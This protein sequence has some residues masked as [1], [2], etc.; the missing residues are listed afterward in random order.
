MLRGHLAAGLI[1]RAGSLEQA[2]LI[3]SN[4]VM[5]TVMNT[6]KRVLVTGGAGFIGSHTCLEL[7]EAG[8]EVVVVDNLINSSE[9]S[10]QRVR[11]LTGCDLCFHRLDLRDADGLD[12]VF[13]ETAFDSVIHFAGLKAV[14]ESTEDPLRYYQ[15]NLT[16]TLVL[17]ETM[18]RHGVQDLVFSSSCTVYGAPECVPISEEAP[19]RPAS[20]YGRT[21]LF[22]EEILRD[23][24]TCESGWRIV[25]L[26]YF[27]PVGA[28]PSGRIGEDPRGIPDNLMPYVTQ[29]A[30]GKRDFVRV[31][32]SDYP[33]PDGTG[34]RDYIHVVDLAQGHL[35]ALA[36]M[37]NER[38]YAA[39]NLGAGRGSSVLEVIR[40]V[41]SIV[42]RDIPYELVAR[43]P[44][45]I[46][47]AWADPELA[48]RKLGWRAQRGLAE[49]C[50]DAWRWQSA[51][52][53]GYG[54]S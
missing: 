17:L 38:E 31:F 48:A 21:K 11:E 52:P 28:H 3:G 51:N 42:G 29:V 22:I 44:G 53:D 43:R 1:E 54:P 7:L 34:I 41:A 40:E 46:A 26:R 37:P 10:L 18:K 50:E 19:L 30:A 9:E 2:R 12:A 47:E 6:K 13:S 20:P 8:C 32:G 14:G 24:A 35:A 5:K 4:G 25:S 27:N 36:S 39:W 33:T 16:S 49:M 45:D 23:I 15:T